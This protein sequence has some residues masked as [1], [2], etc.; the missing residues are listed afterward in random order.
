MRRRSIAILLL[1]LLTLSVSNAAQLP[2]RPS[3]DPLTRRVAARIAALQREA[4]QLAGRSRTLVGDLRALEIE[5]D[6]QVERVTSAEAAATQARTALMETDARLAVLEQQQAAQ[7]PNL[8][9]QLVDLYKRGRG[10][11]ARLLLESDGA[12]DLGRTARAI[13]ALTK[14]SAERAAEH[15]RTLAALGVERATLERTATELR[16]KES[17][18]LA[19]RAAA[20]QAIT[21]RTALMARIDSQRDL[22]AQLAGELEV[23]QQRLQQQVADLAAGRSVEPLTLLLGPFRGALQWPA[24]GPVSARFGGAANRPG[25]PAVRN[26]IEIGSP[27]GTPVTAVH[28]GTVA[29]AAPF[30]GFGQLVIVDHGGNNYSLYGFLSS[31]TVER[32][33]A[34]EAG[35]EVGRVGTAPA[36]P[37][38][39][40]FEMRIDGRSVDPLQW[41]ETR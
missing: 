18:A 12:R 14:I 1:V 2:S 37:A 29:Y 8:K 30:T 31:A 36:G 26:G 34:I 28:G 33:Q 15:K 9:A 32:G 13:S 39:L 7:L 4:E 35:G 19:G 5:R 24:P 41:L 40:Y 17:E 23:A 20:E 27:A 16:A 38:A 6:I 22:N 25:A 3:M 10:G 11:Y 21:A